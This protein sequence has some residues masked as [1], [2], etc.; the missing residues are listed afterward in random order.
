MIRRSTGRLLPE[1]GETRSEVRGRARDD[2]GDGSADGPRWHRVGVRVAAA[3]GHRAVGAG[4]KSKMGFLNLNIHKICS[5]YFITLSLP[6]KTLA[7]CVHNLYCWFSK[8]LTKASR[9]AKAS[10]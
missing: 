10:H 9:D 2:A 7:L 3:R 8:I 6:A 1:N 5:Y 4:C